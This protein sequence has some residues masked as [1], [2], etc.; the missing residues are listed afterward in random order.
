MPDKERV[1]TAL[2]AAYE[3]LADFPGR[4]C[5]ACLKA[6]LWE[7]ENPSYICGPYSAGVRENGGHYT[8]GAILAGP[9]SL[10]G[11]VGGTKG[12]QLRSC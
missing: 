4:H 3:H 12:W 7:E 8:H 10:S 6:P 11:G 2:L 9:G 5:P 1:K